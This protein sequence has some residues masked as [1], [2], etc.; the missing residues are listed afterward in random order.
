MRT[1]A[2]ITADAADRPPFA[3]GTE[4]EI[5]MARWCEECA[6][7]SPELVDRGEGCPLLLIALLGKTPKEW[8]VNPTGG[9]Y[10]CDEF[11]Q[12]PE[13][14]ADDDPDEV[15]APDLRPIETVHVLDGQLDIF[16]G[17]S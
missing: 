11:V 3:N 5:W 16:G 13:W 12:A 7:D 14:P 8:P 10:T 17:G 9:D 1:Q 2:E 6:N 15:E 4:G